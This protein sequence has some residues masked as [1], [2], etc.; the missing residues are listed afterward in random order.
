MKA[1]VDLRNLK[2]DAGKHIIVRNLHRILDMRIL[3]I[4][5]DNGRLFFLYA[6]P[7]TLQK[8]KEELARIGY[9]V[10][11]CLCPESKPLS[12]SNYGRI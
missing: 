4:D 11:S 5:L 2:S 10:Q 8:V 6:T 3:D 7:V 1:I 12:S 9:P